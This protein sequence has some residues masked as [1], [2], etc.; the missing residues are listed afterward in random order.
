MQR[1][2]ENWHKC[3]HE[4]GTQEAIKDVPKKNAIFLRTK[5]RC[6]FLCDFHNVLHLKKILLLVIISVEKIR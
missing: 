3:L 1:E 6:I 5:F 4:Q 2:D